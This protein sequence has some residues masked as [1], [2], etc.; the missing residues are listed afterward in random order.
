MSSLRNGLILWWGKFVLQYS[1]YYCTEASLYDA[2]SSDDPDQRNIAE[3][4]FEERF[5]LQ[6]EIRHAL[7]C[8]DLPGIARCVGLVITDD[9]CMQVKGMLMEFSRTA[10]WGVIAG[11]VPFA[12]AVHCM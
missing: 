4:V 8:Y 11:M 1:R 5:D 10:I 12:T 9:V 6:Q 7:H 3:M 2:R